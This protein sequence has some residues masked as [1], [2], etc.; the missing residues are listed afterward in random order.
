MDSHLNNLN[1]NKIFVG[2][3]I[4][5]L[6]VGSKYISIDLPKSLDN[7]FKHGLL[8]KIVI[9]CLLFIS[10]RDIKISI[11]MTLLFVLIFSIL[12]NENSNACILPENYLNFKDEIDF[13]EDG[14]ISSDEVDLAKTLLKKYK[15]YKNKKQL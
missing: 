10:T 15:E 2:L 14:K 7:I 1:N 13:N 6:N 11:L 8:R 4:I 3:A 12:F 5:L 9:F